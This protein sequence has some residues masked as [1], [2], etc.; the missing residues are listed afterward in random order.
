MRTSDI[1]SVAA[2]KDRVPLFVS[3]ETIRGKVTV[4][5]GSHEGV[6]QHLDLIE[7]ALEGWFQCID[8]LA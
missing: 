4:S 2:R 5:C 6:R 1:R 8:R 3:G 7:F